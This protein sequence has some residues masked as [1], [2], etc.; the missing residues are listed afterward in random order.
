MRRAVVSVLP[1]AFMASYPVTMLFEGPSATRL[2]HT[3]A[4]L[5]W[6]TGFLIWFW[7]KGLRA[8]ASASS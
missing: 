8:Y 7:K 1:Y 2:L 6:A 5:L 3:A 4:V